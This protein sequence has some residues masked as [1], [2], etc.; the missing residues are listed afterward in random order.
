MRD[1]IDNGG[2]GTNFFFDLSNQFLWGYFLIENKKKGYNC[3]L[4]VGFFKFDASFKGLV[5]RFKAW[6]GIEAPLCLCH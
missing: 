3:I 4:L 5:L 2:L 6:A 1:S